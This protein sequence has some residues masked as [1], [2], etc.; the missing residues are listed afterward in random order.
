LPYSDGLRGVFIVSE[1]LWYETFPPAAPPYGA[2]PGLTS[3]CMMRGDGDSGWPSLKSLEGDSLCR[4]FSSGVELARLGRD[5]APWAH[6]LSSFNSQGTALASRVPAGAGLTDS[7]SSRASICTSRLTRSFRRR[8]CS[9]PISESGFT[10]G[11]K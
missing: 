3:V 5:A 10:L 9:F 1:T 4:G 7:E 2:S 8:S 6:S 11:R